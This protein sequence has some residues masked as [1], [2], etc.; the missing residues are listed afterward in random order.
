MEPRAV[1]IVVSPTARTEA[2]FPL[3][4][5]AGPSGRLDVIAR[6]YLA[7][8]EEGSLFQAMLLGGPRGPSLLT[9]PWSCRSRVRSEKSFVLEYV[10][11]VKG[12]SSCMSLEG[13]D[14]PLSLFRR[15]KR[16]GYRLIYLHEEGEDVSRSRD[17]CS[18]NVA[19]VAGS[20]IDVPERIHRFLVSASHRI[21]SISRSR[22]Y[23]TDHVIAYISSLRT[24]CKTL[25]R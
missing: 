20:H 11:A 12:S 16:R 25:K 17:V 13:L 2:D 1:Y 8:W 15:L 22:S 5:Y 7:L 14:E 4:G 3:K 9:V 6:S 23:H 18:D 10:R 24:C 21:L 19:F